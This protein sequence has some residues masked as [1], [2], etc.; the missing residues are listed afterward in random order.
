MNWAW[1]HFSV[2]NDLMLVCLMSTIENEMLCFA[3]KLFCK[4]KKCAKCFSSEWSIW[5]K[6]HLISFNLQPI[7]LQLFHLKCT[8]SPLLYLLLNLMSMI[9]YLGHNL[10]KCV[11]NNHGIIYLIGLFYWV[12]ETKKQKEFILLKCMFL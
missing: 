1:W 10:H 11:S 3:G 8:S 7:S 6:F 4:E 5:M 2:D 12:K 9:R